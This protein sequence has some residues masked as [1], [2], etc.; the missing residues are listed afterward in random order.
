MAALEECTVLNIHETKQTGV[1]DKFYTRTLTST[2]RVVHK[3]QEHNL[4]SYRNFLIHVDKDEVNSLDVTKIREPLLIL[5]PN[6]IRQKLLHTTKVMAR[7]YHL[8]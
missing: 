1:C 2:H 4:I 3:L 6:G 7:W 8:S 5:A